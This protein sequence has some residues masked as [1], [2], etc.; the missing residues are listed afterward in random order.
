MGIAL[1]ARYWSGFKN[2]NGHMVVSL[3][4]APQ[5]RPQNTMI[6]IIGA[7]KKVPS[8]PS[9]SSAVESFSESL[10]EGLAPVNLN[11]WHW[12]RGI[13]CHCS[14]PNLAPWK[15]SRISLRS[16]LN[17]MSYCDVHPDPHA[18]LSRPDIVSTACQA[19][20]ECGGS[21]LLIAL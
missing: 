7:P 21:L 4:G 17:P 15:I 2:Q 12:S 16:T 6:L 9:L 20:V 13:H 3:I 8:Y 5:H 14:H 11:C 1:Y 10:F 19:S 18:S